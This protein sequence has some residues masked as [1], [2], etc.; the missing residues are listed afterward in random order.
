MGWIQ[1]DYDFGLPMVVINVSARKLHVEVEPMRSR[2]EDPAELAEALEQMIVSHRP[3]LAGCQVVQIT[4]PGEMQYKVGVI[5]PSFS[6]TPCYS[7]PPEQRL[8]LCA[9]CRKPILCE[10]D[11]R[12]HFLLTH[13]IQ[14]DGKILEVEVC[15]TEC[16]KKFQSPML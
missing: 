11:G 5:H 8:D 16:F 15:S 4:N 3:E 13:S 12:P 14:M 9:Q 10:G 6:K 1:T 2:V 7:M